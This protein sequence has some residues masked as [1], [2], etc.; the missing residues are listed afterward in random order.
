VNIGDPQLPQK[1]RVN[2]FPLSAAFVNPFGF[3]K[4]KLN[5]VR[6]TETLMLKALPVHLRQSE[7]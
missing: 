6:S 5:L 2:S 3:P 7:Q 4:I 1:W